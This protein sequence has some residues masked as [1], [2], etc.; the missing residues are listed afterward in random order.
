MQSVF[1]H[2]FAGILSAY[3]I[4]LADIVEEEQVRSK[5][6]LSLRVTN[7]M[8]FFFFLQFLG[9]LCQIVQREGFG[10]P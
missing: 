7:A 1:I 5:P 6:I 10:L 9:S 4:G 8:V 2:R 3:G